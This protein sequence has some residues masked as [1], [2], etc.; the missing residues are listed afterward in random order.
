MGGDG[1]HVTDRIQGDIRGIRVYLPL[2]LTDGLKRAEVSQA[3]E[4][5]HVR[6]EGHTCRAS[7]L[8]R[9][10]TCNMAVGQAANR[11]GLYWVGF[12]EREGKELSYRL[13]LD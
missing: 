4:S 6:Y 1:V 7:C 13:F 11:N 8:D 10:V 5:F 9:N 12:F 3:N 2:L